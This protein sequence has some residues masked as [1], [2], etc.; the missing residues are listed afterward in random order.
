MA[1]GPS[2][3]LEGGRPVTEQPIMEPIPGGYRCTFPDD[4]A[5]EAL[6]VQQDHYGRLFAT[7]AAVHRGQLLHRARFNL[8]DQ[9]EQR[10]F[11]RGAASLNGYINWRA[12]VLAMTDGLLRAV[13]PPD[14]STDE[15]DDASALVKDAWPTLD[16][17]AL[18]GLAGVLT[19]AIDAYTEADPLAVLLNILTAF[20][21]LVGPR[22]HFRVEHTKHW[23]RIFAVLVGLTAKGRKGTSWSTPRHVFAAIDEG[24]ATTRVTSGLS[25][26]EG[27]IYAVRD[28]RWEKQPIRQK[29][30]VVDYQRV[31]VDEGVADKRLLLVEEEFAQALK[32]MNREGNILSPILRQAWDTGTLNPLTKT[33]PIMA[34]S[35]HISIIGHITKP[36]LLRHLHDT[37]M[38]NGY[39]N[40]FLWV[41]VRRSKKIPNPTGVPE[42]VLNPLIIRLQKA[43]EVAKQ[44]GEMHRDAEAEAWWAELYDDLSEGQPGLFGAITAR[45][46]V[47]V[48]RLAA[49]YAAFDGTTMIHVSHLEAALAVWR[50]CEDSA[51]YIFGDSTGD[52]VADRILSALQEKGPLDRTAMRDLFGRNMPSTRTEQALST[53]K[54]AKRITVEAITNLKGGRPQT[55]I[56]LAD[57][58]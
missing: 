33:N 11:H 52:A 19:L 48:M 46:E 1:W 34:T 2:P 17:K 15:D 58:G 9:A 21:N 25:S 26:G 47:Q 7:L 28:E 32:V 5:L 12:R 44:I 40:R 22:A 50:Y 29:G 41:L 56:R 8:L 42:S 24:W 53:L 54:Q 57:L 16:K 6:E 43:V 38:A 30:R 49:I 27:L 20:G 37:E 45:A 39:A 51:R 3:D 31:L 10:D 55:V 13:R 36:E 4:T 23:L 35:A 14:V 18:Y